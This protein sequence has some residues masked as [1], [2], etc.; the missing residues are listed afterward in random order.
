MNTLQSMGV[1]VTIR[2]GR[3]GHARILNAQVKGIEPQRTPRTQR[4]QGV[5]PARSLRPLTR[6]TFGMMPY[7]QCEYQEFFDTVRINSTNPAMI[8]R[9]SPT[10]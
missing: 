5:I 2:R 6:A 3:F 7:E 10:M 9:I 8:P 1:E 4:K